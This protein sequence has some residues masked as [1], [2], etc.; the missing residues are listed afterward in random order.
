V[1]G[2]WAR[3]AAQREKS[4]ADKNSVTN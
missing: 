1:L 4:A 3:R 2:Q